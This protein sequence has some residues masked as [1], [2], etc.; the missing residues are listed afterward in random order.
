MKLSLPFLEKKEKPEYFLAL[1]L[2][3]EKA[4][5]VIFEKTGTTIKYIS[6]GEEEFK[7]TV[8]DAQSE[9]FLDVL[10]K[11]ITRAEGALP[12]SIETHKTIFG[13][14]ESWV[15][16]N[17][18]KKEYLEKLKRASEE[19]E[20]EPV[21]FIVFA[22][23]IINL[24]QK[25]EGAPVTAVLADIGKK[26]ITVS[27]VKA[28][29][30][31]ETKSS[32][33]HENASYTVDTLLK[34]FQTPEVMPARVIIFDSEEEELTQEFMG[35]QWSKSLPFLHLP[36]I[37]NLP[38]DA[39]VKAMLLGAATQMG[40]QLLYDSTR[41][42]MDEEPKKITPE[43]LEEAKP[44]EKPKEEPVEKEEETVEEP[45]SKKTSASVETTVDK[46][47]GQGKTPDYVA[48]DDSMEFF[49]FVENADVAKVPTPKS[50]TKEEHVPERV[51]EEAIDQAP[52]EAK[53]ETE[54]KMGLPAI[55]G[56]VVEQIKKSAG[57]ILKF[58][59]KIN[60]KD[61]NNKK[62]LI[63][64]ASV[65]LLL[66]VVFYLY[67][68]TTKA[69]VS[70]SINPKQDSKTTSVTF[71]S[72]S[73]TDV[74]N[75]VIA[76]ESVSVSEDGTVTKP[77][78][79][80]KDVG[81]AAKGKVT[82]FN[83]SNDKVSLASETTI[84]APNGLKFTL[85]S[86]VNVASASGDA[87]SGI[88]PATATVNVTAANIGQEYNFPSGTKFSIGDN[89]SLA[90]KNDNAFSGGTKKQVT[91]VSKDDIQKAL[92][93]LPKQLEGKARKDIASKVT[94]GRTLLPNFIDESVDKQSFDKKMDEQANQLTLKG[95]VTF[96][97]L[98]YK[99]ADIAAFANS[100]FNSSESELSQKDLGISAKN[101]VTEK[102]DDVSADLTIK[103]NLLPKMDTSSIA[104]Q[105][106][107]VSLQ[108][109]KNIISNF[110]QVENVEVLLKPNIPF[111][112]KNL[113][114]NPKNITIQITSK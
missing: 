2:R 35:H 74:K 4:T 107:G 53:I 65:V 95:T 10:D 58:V 36:Q 62:L 90:A 75:A 73:P 77:A 22:E 48:Q 69:A 103:A 93:E 33:I 68:F 26:F 109:A 87:I 89:S 1:V 27:L 12:E 14:K 85:D 97:G 24:V 50:P 25:D 101:I 54:E 104:K 55:A 56:L 98:S 47:E 43:E 61:F 7:N 5:S 37:I 63:I 21:G 102:N 23:S 66:I 11:V 19:L 6:H 100:L 49:G 79:G 91:V 114:G 31:V 99:N 57:I 52:E 30:I 15:E 41:I 8:E 70:I 80:K 20:L 67:L 38:S 46:S 113:P 34:H 13:L 71:S 3:N 112:P 64:P 76:S 111:L 45:S 96:Q 40:A 82:V 28:G 84:I 92:D 81:T 51:V 44:I 18:I 39:A 78:T 88:N 86:S 9:E 106:A 32:E 16:D 108:K 83:I 29:R 72:S 59:K 105:I 42:D 60:F 17:K 110:P 94:S